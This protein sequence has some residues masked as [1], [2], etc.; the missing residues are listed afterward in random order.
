[1]RVRTRWMAGLAAAAALC[2]GVASRRA[3]AEHFD[4]QLRVFTADKSAQSEMDTTPP[5]G[6]VNPR[7]VLKV[8]ADEPFRVTW[9]LK[10]SSPHGALKGVTIH[11]F[12]VKE[13]KT[14]QKPVPNPAGEAGIV[15]T[16]FTTDMSFGATSSG[17][18]KVKIGDPGSYLV[19]LQ[20]ENTFEE[21]GHEHFSAIDVEVQ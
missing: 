8:R 11:F 21:A 7:P 1:M 2:G 3:G 13:A 15:D 5:I 4:M 16:S 14:G 6:G 20:S 18:L 9:R 12:V 17:A 19:R 10:N